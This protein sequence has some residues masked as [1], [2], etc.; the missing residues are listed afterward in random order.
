MI[1]ELSSNKSSNNLSVVENSLP[2][3]FLLSYCLVRIWNPKNYLYIASSWPGMFYSKLWI[4]NISSVGPFEKLLIWFGLVFYSS[5]S[6]GNPNSVSPYIRAALLAAIALIYNLSRRKTAPLNFQQVILL[7][8]NW[9]VSASIRE[10]YIS[11]QLA[12][13]SAPPHHVIWYLNWLV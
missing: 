3:V 9:L 10:Y 4:L 13:L 12:C 8:F 1:F 7:Y 2:F 11:L 5:P 6:K